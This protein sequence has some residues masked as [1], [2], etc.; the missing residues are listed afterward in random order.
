MY[1]FIKSG[2]FLLTKKKKIEKKWCKNKM[3]IIWVL[4][5]VF[6][7]DLVL[8]LYNLN[9]CALF[10][11]DPLRTNKSIVGP[12]RASPPRWSAAFRWCFAAECTWPKLRSWNREF[13]WIPSPPVAVLSFWR[14]LTHVDLVHTPSA[15]D[16]Q[17]CGGTGAAP[18]APGTPATMGTEQRPDKDTFW[19][20]W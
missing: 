6:C 16:K 15:G 8:L 10:T 7:P 11:L 9:E 18:T 17:C 3:L 20:T 13:S 5:L 4:C 1:L 2:V 19:N 14:A 12:P